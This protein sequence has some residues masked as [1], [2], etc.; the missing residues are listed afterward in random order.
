MPWRRASVIKMCPKVS[1][2]PTRAD[3]LG[4]ETL[5]KMF[6]CRLMA[7]A[8]LLYINLT[9]VSLNRKPL[10]LASGRNLSWLATILV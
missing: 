7:I 3:F 6:P 5:K 1:G 10:L 2:N 9:Y 8:S 4:L